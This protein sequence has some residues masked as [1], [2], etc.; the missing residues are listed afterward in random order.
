MEVTLSM[1]G[2]TIPSEMR[3]SLYISTRFLQELELALQ[4]IGIPA[5][6][7]RP[8]SG[9]IIPPRLNVEH[10]QGCV[11]KAICAYPWLLESAETEWWF[12]WFGSRGDIRE[13]ICPATDMPRA[14]RTIAERLREE[15]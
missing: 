13:R 7:E 12:E 6:Y 8:G 14:A 11:E 2:N 1:V 4:L 3:L 5:R 10:P 9:G 15:A